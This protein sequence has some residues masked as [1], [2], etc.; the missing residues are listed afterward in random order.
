MKNVKQAF[1][2]L[3]H[4]Q[5]TKRKREYSWSNRDSVL[6]EAKAICGTTSLRVTVLALF[7]KSFKRG[8][9]TIRKSKKN[10]NNKL[11]KRS[12]TTNPSNIEAICAQ[13]VME[14]YFYA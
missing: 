9:K 14:L 4:V 5:Q 1:I 11:D 12:K 6:W 7:Y 2:P 3:C 8:T 13:N 10:I